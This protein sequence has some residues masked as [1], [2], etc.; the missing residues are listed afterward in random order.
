M[1]SVVGP[2]L[3]AALALLMAPPAA[4]PPAWE[5]GV[6]VELEEA[7]PAAGLAGGVS[8]A[9]A[10][11]EAQARLLGSSLRAL[12][13]PSP[14]G[15]PSDLVRGV[16]ERH[17]VAAPP[18]SARAIVALDALPAPARASLAVLLDAFLRF[19]A[20]AEDALNLGDPG[21]ALAGRNALLDAAVALGEALRA[22]PLGPLQV[23]PVSVPPVLVIDLASA[24]SVYTEDVALLVD[25]G[26]DDVYFNNAGGSGTGLH[27]PEGRC[28]GL[29]LRPAAALIDLAGNDRYEGQ[30]WCG[31]NGGGRQGFGSLLD[32]S[33][34]DVYIAGAGGTNGGGNGYDLVPGVGFLL[35]AGGN[36]TYLAGSGGT[37][38]GGWAGG[39]GLLVDAGGNDRYIAAEPRIWTCSPW[40]NR[41]AGSCGANGGAYGGGSG[42][43]LDLGGDDAYVAGRWGANGAGRGWLPMN[44]WHLWTTQPCYPNGAP[45]ILGLLLDAAGHDTYL[46]EDG[47]S[48]EDVTVVPKRGEE[49][50]G[51][52]LDVPGVAPAGGR[53]GSTF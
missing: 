17:G 41:W 23:D 34:D 44:C 46:D 5:P 6:L 35:D 31:A 39:L 38:G 7:W 51:A 14:D 32:L 28:Q 11:T 13:H 1:S 37:N 43:L 42:A 18:A 24:P 9:K 50:V 8:L 49:G 47:G 22:S 12:A 4:V 3:V 19:E 36:D 16:L 40:A 33:G 15:A 25:A 27:S 21:L 52:Q 45:F 48:G 30:R 20:A 29:S 26:G 10:A 53:G 2:A